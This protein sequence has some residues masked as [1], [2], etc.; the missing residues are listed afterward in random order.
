MKFKHEFGFNTRL[1]EANR[2][3]VKYP[4][5]IPIIC[6]KN[7][8][9]R[10]EEIDKKKYLVPSDLTLGQFIYVIRKRLKLPSEKAV[11]LFIN[12]KIIRTS[13]TVSEI[14]HT[15]KD[16]DNFLYITYS[17]ENVFG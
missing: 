13:A 5:R 14:Y 11:F 7:T 3:L 4:D 1:S 12:G 6:E 2:V 9:T 15:E 10:L 17:D 8:S 16:F